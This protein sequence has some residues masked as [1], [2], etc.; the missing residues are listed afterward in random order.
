MTDEYGLFASLEQQERELFEFRMKE[1]IKRVEDA[2][3]FVPEGEAI[4]YDLSEGITLEQ[5]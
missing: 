1:N 5:V 3:E 2:L 4:P